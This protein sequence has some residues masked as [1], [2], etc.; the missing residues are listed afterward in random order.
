MSRQRWFFLVCGAL[1]LSL[2]LAGCRYSGF[3]DS[4]SRSKATT[5][6]AWLTGQ[7]QPDGGFEVGGFAGFET[8]DAVL[9]IAENAQTKF[10][11]NSTQARNAVKAVV[12]NGH[13]PLN[14]LDKWDI[15]VVPAAGTGV[16]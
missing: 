7:Q 3:T 12:R 13:T 11:W 16:L 8:P 14:A 5:A 10:F 4:S 1:A 6:T 9:A 15:S 2:A